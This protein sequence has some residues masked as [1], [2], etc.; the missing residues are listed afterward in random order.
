VSRLGYLGPAVVVAGIA[1]AGVG[2]WYAVHARPRPGDIIDAIHIG[3]DETLVVRAESGGERTFLE[4]HARDNL[5]WQA[6]LPHYAGTSRRPAIAWGSSAVTAR[7]ERGGRAEVFAVARRSGK[8]LGG[9]RFAPEREPITT[10]ASGPITLTD[11][12]RAYELVGGTDWHQI[13]GV[14]L[15]T[16]QRIWTAD[17]GAETITD[18]G[19]DQGRVWL[20]Q[21]TRRRTFEAATGREPNR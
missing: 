6:L 13:V 11:H 21:G 4:L 18:G 15:E 2:A 14:D 17:L 1:V 9:F 3:N 19:I 12:H 5:V 8:K 20:I 16:G 10:Q 7:V